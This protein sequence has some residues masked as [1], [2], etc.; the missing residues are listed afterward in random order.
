MSKK[1]KR[2]LSGLSAAAMLATMT[3]VPHVFADG[4]ITTVTLTT[5]EGTQ[6]RKNWIAKDTKIQLTAA[7]GA[8]Y[9]VD[10]VSLV[11]NGEVFTDAAEDTVN[12][13]KVYVA[14]GITAAE[15]NSFDIESITLDG[16][17]AVSYT[18]GEDTATAYFE[19]DTLPTFKVQ[20]VDG[21]AY[22][23][24][25]SL[26]EDYTYQ[27]AGGSVTIE[28][29]DDE[30]KEFQAWGYYDT[31]KNEWTVATPDKVSLDNFMSKIA[32]ATVVD[33]D[34][35]FRAGFTE[36]EPPPPDAIDIEKVEVDFTTP[37]NGDSIAD[38]NIVIAEDAPYTI[39]RAIFTQSQTDLTPLKGEFGYG[40]YYMGLL[41]KAKE[42]YKFTEDTEIGV[43]GVTVAV[44]NGDPS[45]TTM[46]IAAQFNTKG[47][48]VEEVIASAELP[49][50]G[51]PG[52]AE[53]TVTVPDD[54][55]YS[56][57]RVAF[58]NENVKN[59]TNAMEEGK[60]YYIAAELRIE[61][62][63]AFKKGLTA[64][65]NGDDWTIKQDVKEKTFIAYYHFVCG[66]APVPVTL[67]DDTA[68][69]FVLPKQGAKGEDKPDI[70]IPEGKGYVLADSSFR[71]KSTNR[72][73][74]GEFTN[75]TDYLVQV[76]LTKEPGYEFDSSV[77]VTFNGEEPYLLTYTPTK[78]SASY[79]FRFE[80][81]DR[82]GIE[83]VD[84]DF[85]IPE[86]NTTADEDIIITLAD[87]SKCRIADCSYGIS[88][89]TPF[90]GVFE[91]DT[92]YYLKVYLEAKE[93]Y[94]FRATTFTTI[95]GKDNSDNSNYENDGTGVLMYYKFKPVKLIPIEKTNVSFLIPEAGTKGDAKPV[96]DVSD[97]GPYKIA[98]VRFTKDGMPFDGEMEAN[99]EYELRFRLT[100]GEGCKFTNSTQLYIDKYYTDNHI[101][102]EL[103]VADISKNSLDC[104]FRFTP[105]ARTNVESIEAEVEIP[106]AGSVTDQKP[107]IKFKAYPEGSVTECDAL[108]YSVGKDNSVIS[109][110]L[111]KYFE[112]GGSYGI[113]MLFTTEGEYKLSSDTKFTINGSDA[114]MFY[115]NGEIDYDFTPEKMIIHEIDV[116]WDKPEAGDK[117]DFLAKVEV[118]ENIKFTSVLSSYMAKSSYVAN[119]KISSFDTFEDNKYYYLFMTLQTPEGY[120]FADDNVIT[121][122]GEK[123]VYIFLDS[124]QAYTAYYLFS[125]N[126][127]TPKYI[128]KAEITFTEPKSGDKG[129]D[130]LNCFKAEGEGYTVKYFTIKDE[131]D[132][133]KAFSN[134]NYFLY[135]P[136]EF[137]GGR[138]YTGNYTIVT[139]DGYLFKEDMKLFVNGE[140]KTPDKL[141]LGKGYIPTVQFDYITFTIMP[142]RIESAALTTDIPNVGAKG[143]VKPEI[144]LAENAHYTLESAV[145]LDSSMREFKDEFENDEIYYVKA[146]I[147][148]ENGYSFAADMAVKFNGSEPFKRDIMEKRTTVFLKF[149]TP[150]KDKQTFMLTIDP[151]FD[152]PEIEAIPCEE[153]MTTLPECTVENPNGQIFDH[154]LVNGKAYEPGDKINIKADTVIQAVWKDKPLKF[155]YGD[156]D[157][158][159]T[160]DIEDA[161]KL[162]QYINGQSVI[163]GD[164]LKTADCNRDGQIDIEDAVMIIGQINGQ[165]LIPQD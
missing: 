51:T 35:K 29:P 60:D 151:G 105:D 13:D 147:V 27:V 43:K 81:D 157:L 33:K 59:F 134:D 32:T 34:L 131:N 45:P 146:V 40:T 18:S 100:P 52:D 127:I 74:S 22:C 4:E 133:T 111:P 120:E 117:N 70:T 68:L 78:I 118:P 149:R 37:T 135:E 50:A 107:V 38:P 67:I 21:L 71:K 62:G 108:Y 93:G 86:V 83:N 92:E 1:S 91:E 82:K 84:L 164:S 119:N 36:V 113:S 5:V 46:Q 163:E 152:G 42:G 98:D 103:C 144:K 121:V 76:V 72:T 112:Y 124:K 96:L 160:T 17:E 75:R 116:K 66:S 162:I 87:D 69:T 165:S 30:T 129:E 8:Q 150:K 101:G 6:P 156:V 65:F 77:P 26:R 16:K 153:G 41:V 57:K 137:E 61:D 97:G 24:G 136:M 145:Y 158:N 138:T 23:E 143:D 102:E 64:K 7:P 99:G 89:K 85:E 88:E 49:T 94:K 28:F 48:P 55:H 142:E 31:D 80:Y 25:W 63:Y 123:P 128:D 161:V 2:M 122:N 73:F 148:P 125:C 44:V 155:E 159:G 126:E 139:E 110:A 115:A 53:W 10:G 11:E 141:S 20:A 106:T 54:A 130:F 154:W 58:F 56:V 104:I 9:D 79:L 132:E 15:G 90:T 109:Y 14:V 12:G 140:D 3:P 95:N 47:K 114:N 39:E 19:V